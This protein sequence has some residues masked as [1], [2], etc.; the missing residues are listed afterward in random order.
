[1]TLKIVFAA[2]ALACTSHT[3]QAATLPIEFDLTGDLQTVVNGSSG[4]TVDFGGS[5]IPTTQSAIGFQ[6]ASIFDATNGGLIDAN[7]LTLALNITPRFQSPA[8]GFD[9][10]GTY[11]AVAGN[12]TGGSPG[13]S[14]WNISF[15][16]EL[17]GGSRALTDVGLELVFDFDPG[18]DTD[19]TDLGIIDLSSFLTAT[20]PSAQVIQ[21][22]Q[23]L[24]FSTF[25]F[26]TNPF[27]SQAAS[28]SF[29]PFA[30]GSYTV[31]LRATDGGAQSAVTVNV[32]VV[33]AVPLP[34]SSLLLLAGVGG[35]VMVRRRKTK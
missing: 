14:A 25:L 2:V 35:L 22:S 7:L 9:G 10:A 13:T 26:G 30:P 18:Q 17:S 5:G 11:S 29:D 21:G 27:V 24:A 1:M 16:A 32:D 6:D 12:S 33:A 19:E 28:G 8:V 3:V 34:A 31:S 15:F 20:D 23:N 4:T